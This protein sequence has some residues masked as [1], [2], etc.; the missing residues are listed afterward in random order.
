MTPRDDDRDLDERFQAL[1]REETDS[2]PAFRRVWNGAVR[3]AGA[4]RAHGLILIRWIAAAAA[5]T[6][7]AGA[8]VLDRGASRMTA[9]PAGRAL[10]DLAWPLAQWRAP[11]DFL[12]RTPGRD[13]FTTVPRIGM[14]AT[15][16]L[17]DSVSG[18][19]PA[20]SPPKR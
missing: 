6:V 19:G 15:A 16:N 11:T 1:R 14:P 8:A 12:L 17:I 5:V 18:Q 13:L 10:D 4:R 3:M 7:I 2:T 20:A 9:P